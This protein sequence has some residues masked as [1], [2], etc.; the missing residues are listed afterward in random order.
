MRCAYAQIGSPD[1]P[2]LIHYRTAGSGPPLLM[3]HASPLSSA[4]LVPLMGALTDRALVIAPDTPDYGYSD[5]LPSAAEDLS[6][7]VAAMIDLLDALGLARVGVY[8]TA[9]GAQIGIELARA[10]PDRCAFL[11]ADNAAHFSDADQAAIT[12]GYF[13][14]LTPDPLGGHLVRT[15]S[16]A[17]DQ[18]LFFPWQQSHA[19]LPS[20]SVD[21]AAVEMLGQQFLAAGSGYATAYRAAFSN[22]RAERLMAVGVPTTV[23]RWEGSIVKPFTDRLEE[24]PL[25]DTIQMEHCGPAIADRLD[26]LARALARHLNSAGLEA[27]APAAPPAGMPR[28]YLGAN[29]LYRDGAGPP[30]VVLHQPGFSGAV[31]RQSLAPMAQDFTCLWPD[32][33][34]HGL[35]PA[36]AQPVA[37]AEALLTTMVEE[38][39]ET[40]L[41]LALG[42]SGGLGLH[43]A[44]KLNCPVALLNPRPAGN[45]PLPDLTL[46]ASGG[47]WLEAWSWLRLR[48][49]FW[50]WDHTRPEAAL[51]GTANL[52]VQLLNTQLKAALSCGDLATAFGSLD[53]P[54]LSADG[55]AAHWLVLDGDPLGAVSPQVLPQ[56]PWQK[57]K[58]VPELATFLKSIG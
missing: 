13:P 12:E 49:L 36:A 51:A 48:Q 31:A 46:R 3:L 28:D 29:H 14:D 45:V 2:R 7:Y 57:F 42:E 37:A 10:H 33:P 15:W 11:I 21:P 53:L 58:S 4:V 23:M 44:G 40:P 25:P 8:G 22:E 55:V 18:M 32:L 54:L 30:L 20:G 52:S 9:T 17:R 26:G 34:G 35:S 16:V 43:L 56:A 27:A 5:P 38:L 1:Q 39:G 19:R 6:P 24:F 50:P 41:L 47:H